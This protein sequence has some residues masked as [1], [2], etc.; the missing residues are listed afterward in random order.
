MI[1]KLTAYVFTIGS[2]LLVFG[3]ADFFPSVALYVPSVALYVALTSS[4]FFHLKLA[5]IQR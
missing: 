1:L 2:G 4:Y 3:R 5:K